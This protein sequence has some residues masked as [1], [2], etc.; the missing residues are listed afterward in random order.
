MKNLKNHLVLC[1]SMFI[2]FS[3]SEENTIFENSESINN[4]ETA[5]K[6]FTPKPT[7]LPNKAPKNVVCLAFAN[8]SLVGSA[9][10]YCGYSINPGPPLT[11]Q[12]LNQILYGSSASLVFTYNSL[13]I[14]TPS[15]PNGIISFQNYNPPQ[16][17]SLRDEIIN[18]YHQVL[19]WQSQSISYQTNLNLATYIHKQAFIN[20]FFQW[21]T[22]M[23]NLSPNT[24]NY[25]MNNN[26]VTKE[27]FNI[28]TEYNLYEPASEGVYL[29]TPF[30]EYA[31]NQNL[32][33][34]S[35][36]SQYLLTQN[37][38]NLIQQFGSGN[39]NSSQFRNQLN[40]LCN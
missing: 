12:E 34:L 28:F 14:I 13:Y 15:T 8:G 19:I 3:C 20:S 1:I 40:S 24:A 6:S 38:F 27:I 32:R 17:L 33:C 26:N 37:G 9:P 35:K 10:T 21:T 18:F 16:N 23:Q 22:K 29:G 31:N 2:F 11:L 7:N 25:L 4:S 39:I 30:G 36:V 5:S